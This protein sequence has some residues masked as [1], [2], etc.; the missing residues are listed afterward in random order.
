MRV[1]KHFNVGDK[2]YLLDYYRGN[3]GDCTCFSIH[4]KEIPS[5]KFC[6]VFFRS[7]FRDD[8]NALYLGIGN[9]R[10][11]EKVYSV[12]EGKLKILKY[13]TNS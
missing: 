3:P 7:R 8:C 12:R 4:I 13:L 6:V 10:I 11:Y 1:E 2:T 9:Y 5:D